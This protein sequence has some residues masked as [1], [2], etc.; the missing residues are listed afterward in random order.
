[1]RTDR[2]L[3][4][5]KFDKHFVT[6]VTD[7]GFSYKRDEEKIAAETALDGVCV[8]RTNVSDGEVAAGDVGKGL[9]GPQ[10][11]RARVP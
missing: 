8:I 3:R 7:N 10:P 5:H 4:S 11:R 2:A 9:H 1:M 6:A